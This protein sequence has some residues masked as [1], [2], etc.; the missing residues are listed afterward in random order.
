MNT[1][2]RRGWAGSLALAGPL[3]ALAVPTGAAGQSPA[4]AAYTWVLQQNATHA[5]EWL[6]AKDFKS[7]AQAA[8]NLKLLAD[9]LRAR[10]SDA[11]WQAAAGQLAQASSTLQTAAQTSDAAAANSALDELAKAIAALPGAPAGAA[12]PAAA[13][14]GNLR[15]LMLLMDAIRG[16]AKVALLTGQPAAAKQAGL[17]LADLGQSVAAA[18]PASGLTAEQWNELAGA[19]V[20]A[21]EALARAPANDA[22]A[23]RPVFKAVAERCD[24]CHEQRN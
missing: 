21:A 7:L 9:R 16:D 11:G 19:Y 20:A 8:G 10:S 14:A 13:P 12:S 17:V 23:I 1:I 5:R 18:R 22:T 15:A 24:G 3:V 6:A 2:L 4:T